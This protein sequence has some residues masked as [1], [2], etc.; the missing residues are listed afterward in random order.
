MPTTQATFVI[1]YD[2]DGTLAPGNMQEYDF[3]PELGLK[4]E[5]FW[6]QVNE[7]RVHQEADEILAYM[8]K[9]LEEAQHK[10]VAVTKQNFI[11]YGS[12]IRFFTGVESW[13]E[14]INEYG[15]TKNINVK[16]FIISSGLREMIVGTSIAKEFEKIYASGFMYDANNVAHWPAQAVNYTTKTQYLFRINKGALDLTERDKVNEYIPPENRAVP[17]TNM[18]FIG[19]GL[20]DIPCMRLVR[21]YGGHAIAVYT[22]GQEKDKQK[23]LQLVNEKRANLAAVADY[24]EGSPIDIAIKAMIEKVAAQQIINRSGI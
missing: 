10:K 19:D 18:C 20:T 22:E 17:F 21:E 11:D 9:M 23:V 3:I 5:E 4:K 7:L 16:H 6:A 15:Q 1:A 8:Q 24:T 13:F 14:R 2:F 12:K